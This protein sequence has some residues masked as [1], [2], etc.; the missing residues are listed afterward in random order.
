MVTHGD[1]KKDH[2]SNIMDFSNFMSTEKLPINTEQKLQFEL[3][4]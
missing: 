1:K 4:A 3:N 2:E